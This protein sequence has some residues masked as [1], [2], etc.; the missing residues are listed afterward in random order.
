MLSA[1]SQKGDDTASSK[2]AE[3]GRRLQ[4]SVFIIIGLLSLSL[5]VVGIIL[6][7]L[8]TTPFLLLSAA[9]FAK[10]SPRL[11]HWLH[12]NRLFGEYMRRYR[13][14]E[15]IPIEMK[16]GVLSI[17]WV[18]LASSA[19]F[20]VSPDLWYVRLILLGVGIGVTVHILKIKTQIRKKEEREIVTD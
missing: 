14:K 6:P 9:L 11:Y 13:D 16:I 17:L 15:G 3:S 2:L 12:T 5:G 8:P 19:L 1:S 7:L 18:T 10:S 20:A 4:R